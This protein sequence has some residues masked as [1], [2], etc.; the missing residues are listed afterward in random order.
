MAIASAS[1]ATSAGPTVHSSIPDPFWK[2]LGPGPFAVGYR[3]LYEHD[4]KRAW[5]SRPNPSDPGRPIRMTVWYP[6][7]S[8]ASGEPMTYGDYLHHDAPPGFESITRALD[9]SD[10]ASWQSD[11][12]ELMPGDKQAL[13]P[14]FDLHVA[15]RSGAE[16][17]PGRHPLVLY[18]GGKGSRADANVELEEFLA[19]Y[20]YVV[21]TVPQL[22]P[23][24]SNIELGSSSGELA[25]HADDFDFALRVLRG[26]P[27]VATH[28]FA[29]IGHSAG[30]EVAIELAL[31]HPGLKAVMG[32]DGSF[33]TKSGANILVLL[34][35][36]QTKL[37]L[38]AAMF[39][40]KRA[41]GSQGVHLNLAPVDAIRWARLYRR[42]FPGAYHG[43]FA[44]WGMV[45]FV[46]GVPM[47]PN[48]DSHTR[49][50]GV[51]VN[52]AV[53]HYALDF[54]DYQLRGRKTYAGRLKALMQ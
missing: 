13:Q 47:P 45:A 17:A 42:L 3:V 15:S 18:S 19:S 23:S 16:P 48:P 2:S 7:A 53:C 51:D 34:P 27:F 37:E 11:M 10:M 6:A 54:L 30:A 52:I 39:D 26:L 35:G 25:L 31:R 29:A 22:G 14:I 28:S 8:F 24:E 20:G 12:N 32:F 43:D 38:H 33:G 1:A 21:A 50:I 41:E 40:L 9:Q 49:Q 4:R 44:E 46:A 5:L 36:Y